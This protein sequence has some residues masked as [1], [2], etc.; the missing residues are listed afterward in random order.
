MHQKVIFTLGLLTRRRPRKVLETTNL[1]VSNLQVFLSFLRSSITINI[2]INPS[3]STQKTDTEL[4]LNRFIQTVDPMG[5]RS[6]QGMSDINVDR[7]HKNTIIFQGCAF[8]N[9]CLVSFQRLLCTK[10]L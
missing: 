6:M 3:P 10:T 7:F 1:N 5:T 4:I 2:A 8:F 9:F